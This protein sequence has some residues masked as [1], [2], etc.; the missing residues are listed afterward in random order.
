MIVEN[1]IDRD[2]SKVDLKQI[3]EIDSKALSPLMLCSEAGQGLYWNNLIEIKFMYSDA[4]G[5]VDALSTVM[6]SKLL[7]VSMV[8]IKLYI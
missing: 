5:K 7:Q 1:V 3:V 6:G 8:T 2:L 4:S